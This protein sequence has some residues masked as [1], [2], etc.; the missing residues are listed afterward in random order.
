MNPYGMKIIRV[1]QNED[2]Q[3]S[4]KKVLDQEDYSVGPWISKMINEEES[5]SKNSIKYSNFKGI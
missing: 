5:I 1:L 3:H 4:H 2:I